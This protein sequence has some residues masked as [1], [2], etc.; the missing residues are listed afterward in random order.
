M[1]AKDKADKDAAAKKQR[2]V[3]FSLAISLICIVYIRYMYRL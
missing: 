1:K 3:S 2:S